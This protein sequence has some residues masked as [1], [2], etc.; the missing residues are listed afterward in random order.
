MLHVARMATLNSSAPRTRVAGVALV[1]TAA[2]RDVALRVYVAAWRSADDSHDP[3]RSRDG[4]QGGW[5]QVPSSS[6]H[7]SARDGLLPGERRLGHASNSALPGAQEYSAHRAI[8]GA[9]ATRFK[10]F[11]KD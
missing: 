7:A 4:G 10:D 6:S 9:F 2:E 3:F 5:H 1:E 11:W 8:H